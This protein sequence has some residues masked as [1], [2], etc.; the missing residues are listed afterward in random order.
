MISCVII[1]VIAHITLH[2]QDTPLHLASIEGHVSSVTMLM[3]S[4][5]EFTKNN[6][7]D[8]FFDLAI[9]KEHK[10]V[11]VAIISHERQVIYCII[12]FILRSM[13]S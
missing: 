12:E 1:M 5:A 3:T 11:C 10:D 8:H 4:G 2:L 7:N 6:S 13:H 9:K